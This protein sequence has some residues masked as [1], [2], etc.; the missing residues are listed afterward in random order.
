M[1]RAAADSPK[2]TAVI[3]CECNTKPRKTK[4]KTQ[5]EKQN[6]TKQNKSL[7]VSGRRKTFNHANEQKQFQHLHNIIPQEQ[8]TAPAKKHFF[9]IHTR[10][11]RVKN[12]NFIPR[13]MSTPFSSIQT[14]KFCT[15][16][17][18]KRPCKDLARFFV[19][20]FFCLIFRQLR[21][22]GKSGPPQPKYFRRKKKIRKKKRGQT[23]GCACKT[24]VQNFKVYLSKTSCAFG[25]RCVEVS[26]IRY[27]LQITWF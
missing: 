27:F 5:N 8:K 22:F 12:P 14:V 18:N 4:Q 17:I 21:F 2:T 26:K 6:K 9:S 3:S 13:P 19:F 1:P 7:R 23:S 25:L 11:V 10:L 24:R 20:V 15:S 16:S